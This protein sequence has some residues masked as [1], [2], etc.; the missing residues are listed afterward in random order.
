MSVYI[1][2]II[3]MSMIRQRSVTTMSLYQYRSLSPQLL[4]INIILFIIMITKANL[5]ESVSSM[6][7]STDLWQ[8][9]ISTYDQ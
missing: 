8:D 6:Q 1:Y 9:W 5:S 4:L 7:A 3:I 2:N